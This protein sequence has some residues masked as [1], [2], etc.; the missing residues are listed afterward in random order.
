MNST[1][2]AYA[3]VKIDALLTDAGWSLTDGVSVLFENT[4]PDGTQA[5]Y[6]I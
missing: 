4:L 2:E 5:D 6:V 3:C 1:T